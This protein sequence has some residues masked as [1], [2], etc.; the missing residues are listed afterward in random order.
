MSAETIVAVLLRATKFGW[1]VFPSLKIQDHVPC[2]ARWRKISSTITYKISQDI[3]RVTLQMLALLQ[4]NTSYLNFLLE[5]SALSADCQHFW[6]RKRHTDLHHWKSP[7]T[8][9]RKIK[10]FRSQELDKSLKRKRIDDISSIHQNGHTSWWGRTPS[11]SCRNSPS[12]IINPDNTMN[13]ITDL[14]VIQL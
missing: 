6:L 3:P 7:R 11:L 2:P 8:W 5:N 9:R 13:G 4:T 12:T 10:C 14:S 1:V